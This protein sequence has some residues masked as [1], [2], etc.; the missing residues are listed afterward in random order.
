MSVDSRR[1]I[2]AYNRREEKG[3]MSTMVERARV[4]R[5]PLACRV[6][7]ADMAHNADIVRIPHPTDEDRARCEKYLRQRALLRE[8]LE[9]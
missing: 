5:N 6:K 7:I 2:P 3:A 1:Q 9:C 8:S 4:M